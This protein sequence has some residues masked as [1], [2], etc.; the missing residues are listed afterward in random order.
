MRF[1]G[2]LLL[3]L[4]DGLAVMV[5]QLSFQVACMFALAENVF[6][7]GVEYSVP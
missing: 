5:S 1:R 7:M 6:E 3:T 2:R 4:Q